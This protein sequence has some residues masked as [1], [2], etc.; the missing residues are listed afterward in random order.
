MMKVT[1][2]HTILK[3]L[4]PITKKDQYLVATSGGLDSVVLAYLCIRAELP[5]T[6]AHCNFKLRG[7]ESD[8]DE[9]L[10]RQLGE[11]WGVKVLVKSF[12]TAHYAEQKQ[13]SIQE[14]ARILRYT[15]FE[16]LTNTQPMLKWILT[17]HHCDENG[18]SLLMT[19]F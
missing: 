2:I 18:V 10:V 13:L 1:A 12:E 19:F 15:W 17:A 8:R 16:E 9:L 4:A 6:L 3:D 11:Q 14:A 7:N 5:I